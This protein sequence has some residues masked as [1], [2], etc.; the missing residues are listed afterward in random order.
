MAII[1]SD[2]T[3]ICLRNAIQFITT[4]AQRKLRFMFVN[5][6]SLCYTPSTNTLTKKIV[7]GST[8]LLDC[9]VVFN[10]KRK[11]SMILE[12]YRLQIPIVWLVHS[13]MAIEYYNKITYLIPCNSCSLCTCF[14]I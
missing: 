3:L 12:A 2:R 10:S 6:N 8:Q 5:T 14:A 7:S 4:M 13:D 9:L 11:S 1:D